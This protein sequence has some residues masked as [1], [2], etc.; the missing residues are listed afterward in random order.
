M[1][2]DERT[3][4]MNGLNDCGALVCGADD[5]CGRSANWC[6]SGSGRRPDVLDLLRE[7]QALF[8]GLDALA[9]ECSGAGNPCPARRIMLLWG[10]AAA[11][12]VLGL[13]LSVRNCCANPTV[14]STAW[15]WCTT[16]EAALQTTTHL[17]SFLGFRDLGRQDLEL[18][19]NN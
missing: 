14:I 6:V 1:T 8:G 7:A 11:A 9:G 15:R 19:R 10:F 3:T 17:E 12:V 5:R 2:D 4:S 13:L 16:K 18:I